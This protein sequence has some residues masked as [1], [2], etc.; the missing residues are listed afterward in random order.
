MATNRPRK[1]RPRRLEGI[2]RLKLR[3]STYNLWNERKEAVGV[4]GLTNSEFAEMLLHQNFNPGLGDRNGS[5]EG[6]VHV[7]TAPS[8]SKMF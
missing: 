6:P 2:K 8:H 7:N 5:G 3:E 1:G 4:R